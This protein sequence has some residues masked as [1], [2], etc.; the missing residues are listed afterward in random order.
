M[1]PSQADERDAAS[2][3]LAGELNRIWLIA[4]RALRAFQK[5]QIRP[6]PGHPSLAEVES[7]LTA[8]R[9]SRVGP[10]ATEPEDEEKLTALISDAETKLVPLRK[11]A[12][13][14]RLVEY[15]KLQPLEIESLVTIMAPHV[16]PPLAEM[17]NVIRG[18]AT[19]RRGVDLALIGQLFR[20]KRTD[21]VELLDV[22][23]AE[24]PLIHWKLIQAVSAESAESFGSVSHRALRPTFDLLSALAARSQLAPELMRYARIVWAEAKLDDLVLDPQVRE[25][26]TA[27][28]DAATKT[29][30]DKMPW[31]VVYGA[32]GAG[33]RTIASRIAA[34]GGK[35][36]VTFD[37][38]LVEKGQFDELFPRIQREALIRGAALYIGPIPPELLDKSAS[39]LVKRLVQFPA[40]LILG[41][42]ASEPPRISTDNPL[43]ELSLPLPSEAA[44]IEMWSKAVPE[45]TRGDDLSLESIARGFHLTP[46]DIQRSSTEAL[47]VAAAAGRKTTH[48][49]VR[50]GVE[51]RLRSDLGDLARRIKP[52]TDWND[53]VLPKEELERINEFISRKKY[54]DVVYEQWG[55]GKRVGYGKGLIGLFSGPPGTGKTMLAGLIA[56]ALD[57]DLYQ[58]DLGQVV[59]KWVG[60]TE[61]QLGKVFDQAERA[62]AVLLFDEADSMFAKRTEV[63][64][65]NDRYANMAVNYLLQRLERYTGVAVLTTNKDASLDD[66]LQRRLTLHLRLEIPEVE[67]RER[68]WRTFMPKQAPVEQD[69]SFNILAKE[70]EL[71][72][73]YIKNAAVRAAFLA[74]AHNAP[75]GME[76]LRLASALELEDMGRV[77]MQRR[78]EKGGFSVGAGHF[79]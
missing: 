24:R 13:I 62:H 43:Q 6:Q 79:S 45:N 7:I 51:R 12:P 53:L 66:A 30:L 3:W 2:K 35:A 59:S 46:G 14:R 69:I 33:K 55:Y 44:R 67:E 64:T 5:A 54:Y 19:G 61:K 36:L 70:F 34:Y 29:K 23:D 49:E 11:A 73:G 15:L 26:V 48:L 65:S 9:I 78:G 74:A 41:V 27:L 25:D 37:P 56:Q 39:E 18:P 60:E 32:A 1:L 58:V 28:C 10:T 72:G 40:P 22:V 52:S 17:F 77:V 16:D 75:I 4:E 31:L 63:K 50:T 76:L 71:S 42:D 68:L 38:G 20:L 8:R 21:R 47:A 57:L